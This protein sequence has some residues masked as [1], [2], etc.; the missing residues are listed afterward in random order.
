MHNFIDLNIDVYQILWWWLIN[1]IIGYG[2]ST[3]Q[4]CGANIIV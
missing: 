4:I 2:N 1:T 3:M